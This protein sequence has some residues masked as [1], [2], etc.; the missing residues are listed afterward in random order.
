[1]PDILGD[2]LFETEPGQEQQQALFKTIKDIQRTKTDAESRKNELKKAIDSVFSSGGTSD[3]KDDYSE[4]HT[5]NPKG[6]T[7]YGQ[8]WKPPN[9][10]LGNGHL[11]YMYR[12]C[13]LQAI[14][15]IQQSDLK[16]KQ[17]QKE[18]QLLQSRI[19]QAVGN[20]LG[21]LRPRQK[22]GSD[23]DRA[24]PKTQNLFEKKLY[25]IAQYATLL[26]EDVDILPSVPV[27]LIENEKDPVEK[28]LEKYP[29]LKLPPILI[30]VHRGSDVSDLFQRLHALSKASAKRSIDMSSN[31]KTF[32]EGKRSA[33]QE[34][35]RTPGIHA[36][37]MPGCNHMTPDEL[38]ILLEYSPKLM[39]FIEKGKD[40]KET[41][42]SAVTK[43]TELVTNATELRYLELNTP[44]SERIGQLRK[45]LREKKIE[46]KFSH[47]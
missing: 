13:H 46:T 37:S 26:G 32:L 8:K 38:K 12:N 2:K 43:L 21:N 7:M 16:E 22:N 39:S 1:M 31:L 18:R 42:D 45:T 40:D 47:R 3:Y 15:G 33:F 9:A 34:L 29:N 27:S 30:E 5:L 4:I 6:Y 20:I 25:V 10:F 14:R 23:F 11:L 41:E 24:K 28:F 35:I 17:E 36:L 44:S 19:R